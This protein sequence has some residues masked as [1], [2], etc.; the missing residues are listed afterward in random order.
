MPTGIGCSKGRISSL[1]SLISLRNL[2]SFA[3]HVQ[4]ANVQRVLLNERSPG[5]DLVAHEDG[6]D[7]VGVDVVLDLHAQQAA[8]G[9]V[10]GGFPELRRVHL[11]ATFVAL[12]GN[13]LLGAVV[14]G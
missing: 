5:L 4:V 11:A 12:N 8:L 10:H 13:A 2:Y 1:L 3:L 6:E 9:G 7:G 14:K